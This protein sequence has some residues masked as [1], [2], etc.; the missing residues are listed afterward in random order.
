MRGLCRLAALLLTVLVLVG[1]VA[2]DLSAQSTS[3]DV[4]SLVRSMRSQR[5]DGAARDA[6]RSMR[7][8]P[9]EVRANLR[10]L[11]QRA[12]AMLDLRKISETRKF[13][14][15]LNLGPDSTVLQL[16]LARL[17]VVLESDGPQA[18]SASVIQLAALHRDNLDVSALHARVL[19]ALED[20]SATRRV[21]DRLK[22]ESAEW[23]SNELEA[24]LLAAR[25]E[26]LMG[27]DSLLEHA[28]PLLEQALGRAPSRGDVRA[29]YA[30]ALTRWQRF[31]RA[32]Q[33]LELGLQE[34]GPDRN[35]LLMAQGDLFRS[36]DRLE[37][38][39][40]CY[41][42]VLEDAR[43]N[44]GAQVGLARCRSRMGEKDL[45]VSLLESCLVQQ[46]DHI[47]ALL[48]LAGIR[49]DMGLLDEAENLLKRVLD[50]RPKHLKACW[51]LSRV[52]ARSGRMDEV[53]VLVQ[54]YEERLERLRARSGVASAPASGGGPGPGPGGGAQDR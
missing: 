51:R 23:T 50:V 5:R 45:A 34:A 8:A 27:D 1:A 38:A 49:E 40:E 39:V 6:L 30:Q 53:D 2:P 54:R 20:F 22:G 32:E 43:S 47:D 12:L 48:V 24:E 10:V 29:L 19:M 44:R 37:E 28:L 15:G 46:P 7:E 21:L 11:G 16:D 33:E 36:T 42:L 3:T 35:L 17:R 9:A 18:V 41:E 52:L 14:G 4:S 13:L 31:E 26:S 25:A